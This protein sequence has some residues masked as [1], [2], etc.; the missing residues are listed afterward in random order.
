VAPLMGFELLQAGATAV[1]DEWARQERG[2]TPR[3]VTGRY[4]SFGPDAP[5][6]ADH[7]LQ[8][9]YGEAGWSIARADTATTRDELHQELARLEEA[10]VTDVVMF[11]CAADTRQLD[12]L[13]EALDG[14]GHLRPVRDASAGAG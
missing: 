11:P 14:S 4:F 10:G 5:G 2:G 3:I 12:L 7:Y 9:Y 6:V 1:R 13:T 8:H